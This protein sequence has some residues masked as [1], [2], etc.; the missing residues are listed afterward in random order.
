MH[1]F[2]V[3][4]NLCSKGRNCGLNILPYGVTTNPNENW[5]RQM[6]RNLTDP[7]TGFLVSQASK[8]KNIPSGETIPSELKGIKSNLILLHDRD[9]AQKI[10]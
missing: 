3:G 7:E 5:M 6:A 1:I 10:Y 9:D 8:S 4:K 2:L